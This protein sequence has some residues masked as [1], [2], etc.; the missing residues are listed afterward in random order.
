M[1]ATEDSLPPEVR[2]IVKQAKAEQTID[3]TKSA[4]RSEMLSHMSPLLRLAF[5]KAFNPR[6]PPQTQQKWFTISAYLVQTMA[7]VVRDL[8]YEKIRAEVDELKRLVSN[9]F[10]PSMGR[11]G[12]QT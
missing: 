6:S 12:N 9:K 5:R 1:S 7:R 10:V 8:E 11:S 4:T 2:R 3:E